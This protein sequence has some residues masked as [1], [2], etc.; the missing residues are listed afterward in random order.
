MS[1]LVVSWCESEQQQ[2]TRVCL[3]GECVHCVPC[4]Y[5]LSNGRRTQQLLDSTL[6]TRLVFPLSTMRDIPDLGIC[7]SAYYYD[8]AILARGRPRARHPT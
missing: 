8:P 1:D 3:D 2:E 6:Q 7:L 5:L 4:I